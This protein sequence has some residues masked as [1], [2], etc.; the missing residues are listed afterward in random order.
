[1]H[2][3][4]IFLL[5]SAAV[6]CALAQ[7]PVA[8]HAAQSNICVICTDPQQTYVCSVE[9]SQSMPNKKALQFYCIVKTAKDGG[10]RVCSIKTDT[11][12]SCEGKVLSYHYDGPE[13]PN[14]LRSLTQPRQPAAGPE[15][16]AETPPQHKDQPETLVE[17]GSRAVNASKEGAKAT[18]E[19]IRDAAGRPARTIGKIRQKTGKGVGKTAR[20]AGSAAR[21]A[22][23]CM[24]SLFRDCK[25]S[26]DQETAPAT[27]Q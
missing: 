12:A 20:G 14:A 24:R 21:F 2:R 26:D 6:L 16:T 4:N 13:I 9:T 17:M 3:S 23:D 15:N 22:Y 11:E 25:S 8:A 19:V 18:G 5:R 27:T 10:H 7:M 1:M